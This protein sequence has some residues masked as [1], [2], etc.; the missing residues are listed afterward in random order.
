MVVMA[1]EGLRQLKVAHDCKCA[2]RYQL[3]KL[4][5]L[6]VIVTVQIKWLECRENARFRT[7]KRYDLEYQN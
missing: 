3:K 7:R 5:V 4:E 2:A 6:P 1:S